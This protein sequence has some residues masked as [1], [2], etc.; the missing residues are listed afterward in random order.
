MNYYSIFNFSIYL[1]NKFIKTYKQHY[2]IHSQYY[3]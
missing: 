1:M 2:N 3:M